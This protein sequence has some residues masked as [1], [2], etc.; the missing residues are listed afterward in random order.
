MLLDRLE[1][2]SGLN[3]IRHCCSVGKNMVLSMICEVGVVHSFHRCFFSL[4][5]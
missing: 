4:V 3:L 5:W 1:W 2:G